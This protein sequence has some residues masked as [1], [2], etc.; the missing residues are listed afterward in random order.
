MKFYKSIIFGTLAIASTQALSSNFSYSY[1]DLAVGNLEIGDYDDGEFTSIE[2]GYQLQGNLFLNFDLITHDY[3][4]YEV[5]Y[6]K[7]GLGMFTSM[8]SNADLYGT[9][10]IVDIETDN[11]SDD[12][13]NHLELGARIALTKHLEFDGKLMR[14]KIDDDTTTGYLASARFYTTPNLAFGGGYKV[15]EGDDG[16][17]DTEIVYANIRFN[18]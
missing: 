1:L 10:Q 4:G 12:T 13:G 17:N 15:W 2:G 6:I 11:G 9:F 18:F 5:E 3:S 14:Q 8:G 16:A 7:Y